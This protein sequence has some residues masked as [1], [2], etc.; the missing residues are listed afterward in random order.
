MESCYSVGIT[1]RFAQ[2]LVESDEESDNDVKQ[3]IQPQPVVAVPATAAK[4]KVAVAEETQKK[5]KQFQ[6]L[7]TRFAD[8]GKS[9]NN[10][11]ARPVKDVT[12]GVNKGPAGPMKD[13]TQAGMDPTRSTYAPRPFKYEYRNTRGPRFGPYG[14]T[15]ENAHVNRNVKAPAANEPEADDKDRKISEN[16]TI[17]QGQGDEE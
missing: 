1:N 4:I 13:A 8:V 17:D 2:L 16:E 15:H 9:I 5:K 6:K 12:Y 7:S 3:E 11:S 10:G 14:T